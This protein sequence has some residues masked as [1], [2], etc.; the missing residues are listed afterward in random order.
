MSVQETQSSVLIVEDDP[1]TR[2]LIEASFALSGFGTIEAHNGNQAFEKAVTMR[3]ALAVIDLWIPGIDGFA[4]TQK[5]KADPR[6]ADIPLLAVTGHDGA[7]MNK[8]VR[9][10][11]CDALLIKPV[12][13]DALTSMGRLLIERA[14]LLREQSRRA[15]D[16][17]SVLIEHSNELRATVQ[18]AAPSRPIRLQCRF[19]GGTDVT[20]VHETD[21]TAT[22]ECQRCQKRWRRG[23]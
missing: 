13:P 7:D 19:C 11:G 22:L 4:L 14:I 9:Q 16:R 18:T 21:H 3:P 17:T 12:T 8:R 20:L 6:T 5:L 2:R 10:A 1:A 15:R 23:R